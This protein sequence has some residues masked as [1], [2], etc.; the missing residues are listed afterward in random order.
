MSIWRCILKC[1]KPT[2]KVC[3]DD[4][5]TPKMGT[6]ESSE[7]P[8]NAEYN[9][10][11]QTPCFEVFFIPLKRSWSVDVENGLTWVKHLKH[12]LWMKE[13]LGVKLLI[14]LS[15]TKSQELTRPWCVQ[16]EC[17]TP[18][19][20]SQSELQVC[21]RPHCNRRYEQGVMNSQSPKSPN[22]D[23]FGTPLWESRDKKPFE[24]GCH[25]EAQ[26][27]LYGGRWWLPPSLSHGESCE[28]RVAHGLS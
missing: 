13:R 21:F 23:N 26:R 1:R 9:C 15:T 12:K 10:R 14:W 7:T 20:S 16:V 25:E 2:L 24:C 3:E 6:W 4:T 22:S 28:S 19:K 18:L 17:D 5:H 27:I 11:G 8:K